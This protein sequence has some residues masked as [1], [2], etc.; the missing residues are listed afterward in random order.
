MDFYPFNFQELEGN[1]QRGQRVIAAK[2]STSLIM[3]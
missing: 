3:T 1:K 2:L